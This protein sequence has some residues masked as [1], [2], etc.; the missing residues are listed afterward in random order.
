MSTSTINIAEQISNYLGLDTLDQKEQIVNDLLQ[1][2]RQMFR[3]YEKFVSPEIFLA[4]TSEANSLNEHGDSPLLSLIKQHIM[5]QWE[6]SL[7]S[8]SPVL[9]FINRTKEE[10]FDH[11]NRVLQTTAETGGTSAPILLILIQLIFQTLDPAA[12]KNV[13]NEIFNSLTTDGIQSL[14]KFANYIAGEDLEEQLSSYESP[15]FL[16]LL[17]Y[18]N[19]QIPALLKKHKIPNTRDLYKLAIH[20]VTKSGLLIGL[21]SVR[22]KIAPI[23]Y[24]SLTESLRDD[25]PPLQLT[26]E[27]A[28]P[29]IGEK[30]SEYIFL[31][32]H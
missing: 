27:V 9:L 31:C 19:D 2:G 17:L 20:S 22:A 13:L 1:N 7:Q 8:L 29:Q 3:K 26:T 5:N 12:D 18:N 23:S 15:I 6:L 28:Q 16:S 32:V 14:R 25:K 11:F 24:K 30:F 4:E 10:C 21:E